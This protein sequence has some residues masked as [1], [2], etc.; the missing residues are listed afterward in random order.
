MSKTSKPIKQRAKSTPVPPFGYRMANENDTFC[1]ELLLW[2]E[3]GKVWVPAFMCAVPTALVDAHISNDV[4]TAIPDEVWPKY[5]RLAGDNQSHV[6][7]ESRSR[8]I[9]VEPSGQEFDVSLNAET[10]IRYLGTGDFKYVSPEEVREM[11]ATSKTARPH[12][13][14]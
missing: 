3:P 1:R 6:R 13:Q 14:K 10:Y 4:P 11:V 9:L 7:R 5:I 2:L 8:F 12:G